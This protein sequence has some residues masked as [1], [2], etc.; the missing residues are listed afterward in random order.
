[1][2]GKQASENMGDNMVKKAKKVEKVVNKTTVADVK[3]VNKKPEVK[4]NAIG[5][6]LLYD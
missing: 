4:R 5:E 1:M 2:R 6:V 3:K